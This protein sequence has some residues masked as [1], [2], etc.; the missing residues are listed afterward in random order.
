MSYVINGTKHVTPEKRQRV[1][2]V[3]AKTNYQPN[4]VAKSLRTKKTNTI[5]VLSEGI[6]DFPTV[7]IISGISGYVEQTE[8]QILL[9]DLRMLDCLFN[10]YD[11]V[12][13]Q[14]D[15]INKALSYLVF[16]AKV[17]A[18]IYLGMFDRDITGIISNMNKP[19]VVAYCTSD[20]DFTCSV[21]YENEDVSASLTQHL[22]DN[23]HERIAVITGL[24][25]TA[26]AQKRLRGIHNAFEQSGRVLDS[27]MVKNGDWGRESGYSCMMELLAQCKDMPPTAVMAMNDLMAIGVM[28]AIRE[29]NLRIP[30]DISIVGFDNREVSEFVFP[31]LTTAEIDLKAIGYTAAKVATQKLSGVGEYAEVSNIVVPSKLILRDTVKKII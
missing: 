28:D 20:D 3:I 10:R 14:K 27:G 17:D 31:K 19:V 22:F 5:G 24:S 25:N 21:T 7:D 16:G 29:A 12:V 15:K 30:E 9:S 23:G 13:H 11:Q 1:L 4:R 2:N 6:L 8:Y 26:P 18:I